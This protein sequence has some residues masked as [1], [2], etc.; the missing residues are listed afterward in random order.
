[1]IRF[2]ISGTSATPISTPRSPRATMTASVSARISSQRVDRL[3]L[4]DLRDHA[5]ARAGVLDQLAQ[6]A[7]VGRGADERERD[8]VDVELEREVEVLEVLAASA[9]GSASAR[10]GG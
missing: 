5:R 1:M 7:D 9:T 3:G 6:I 4:L 8:V 10:P 2:W